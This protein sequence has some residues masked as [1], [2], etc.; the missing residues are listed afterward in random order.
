MKRSSPM[1]IITALVLGIWW[2]LAPASPVKT[3]PLDKTITVE[4][5]ISQLEQGWAMAIVNKDT[6]ALDRLL[7]K[8]FNG[9]SAFA[10]P[11]SRE[12]AI[13]DIKNGVYVVD[14]MEF[15]DITVKVFGNTAIAFTSENEISRYYGEDRSGHYHCTDV[16][17]KR[18]GRWEVVASH[19]SQAD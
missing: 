6:M 15:D 18:D 10:E 7:A 1:L 13:E 14:S 16:W 17:V 8:D 9:T 12:M 4:A 3:A 11:Y 5:I 2:L 19:A